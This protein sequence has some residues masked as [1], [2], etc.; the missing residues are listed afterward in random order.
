[1][2]AQGLDE[3]EDEE[4]FGLID[5]PVTPS[6]SRPPSAG[7]KL[8]LARMDSGLPDSVPEGAVF[9]LKEDLEVLDVSTAEHY[10]LTKQMFDRVAVDGSGTITCKS[11][12]DQVV[13]SM[14]FHCK[15]KQSTRERLTEAIDQV[16]LEVMSW[17]LEQFMQWFEENG[18]YAEQE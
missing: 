1:M 4:D 9:P 16:D 12:L 17:D 15:T 6:S 2:K 18:G 14:M 5:G 11:E 8:N 7:L 13:T 10:A 3:D